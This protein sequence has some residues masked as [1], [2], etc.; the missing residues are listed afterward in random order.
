[1]MNNITAA[2]TFTVTVLYLFAMQPGSLHAASIS[3]EA[4]TPYVNADG[5]CSLVEAIDNAND[6]AQTHADC[7]PGSGTDI[8]TLNQDVTLDGSTTFN[9]FGATGLPA[10]TSAVTIEGNDKTIQR[11]TAAPGFRLLSVDGGATVTLQNLTLRGGFVDQGFDNGGGVYNGGTLTLIN[12]TIADN[13]VVSIF[14]SGGGIYNTGTLTIIDSTVQ[15]NSVNNATNPFDNGGGVYS[16]GALT[17]RNSTI[18]GNTAA[19]SGGGIYVN[20]D[21]TID[22]SV[23]S[24]NVAAVNGGGMVAIGGAS[25]GVHRIYNTTFSDNTAGERGGGL[26]TGSNDIEIFGSTF[27]ANT[28]TGSSLGVGGGIDASIGSITITNSTFDGNRALGAG[29]GGAFGAGITTT[30]TINGSVFRNN[31]AVN[32]GGALYTFGEVI[33]NDSLISGNTADRGG[34]LFKDASNV[35][36]FTVNRS[37]VIGNSAT[38]FGGGLQ[39]NGNIPTG[40]STIINSTFTGNSTPGFAGGGIMMDSGGIIDIRYS[41]VV[42]NEAT[43]VSNSVGGINA[44]G[45]EMTIGST[46]V[47]NNQNLDCSA[48]SASTSLDFNITTGVAD[49]AL[50][51][52]CSFIP[53]QP[54]DQTSTDPLL[55]PISTL[56]NL[57]SVYTLQAGSPAAD[58]V[59]VSC[60]PETAGVD[61]RGVP[62]EPGTCDVGS[63]SDFAAV[64]PQVY[65][66]DADIVIDDEG[67]FA[68]VQNVNIVVDNTAGNLPAPGS[69]PLTVYVTVLGTAAN[70]LDHTLGVTTPTVFAFNAGNWVTPGNTGTVS[71]PID[72]IDDLLI[73]GDETIELALSITGPGEARTGQSRATVTIVDDDAP[74]FTIGD[75]LAVNDG[76]DTLGTFTVVLDTPPT[77]N[78][79]LDVASDNTALAEVDTPTLMFDAANWNVPQTV[80][81]TRVV[82]ATADTGETVVVRVG[83]SANN[84][85]DAFDALPAQTVDVINGVVRIEDGNVINDGDDDNDDDGDD[86]APTPGNAR[87]DDLPMLVLDSIVELQTA[88]RASSAMDTLTVRFN[89]T[90][91]GGTDANGAHNPNNYILTAPGSDG[92]FDR[93]LTCRDWKQSAPTTD[94]VRLLNIA[95]GFTTGGDG[96]EV[97]LQFSPPLAAG[98]YRLLVCGTSSIVAAADERLVLNNGAFDSSVE[99]TVGDPLASVDM[100]PATGELPRWR[101]YMFVAIGMIALSGAHLLV[102]LRRNTAQPSR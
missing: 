4:P 21:A 60:P 86:D 6:D 83:V 57:Q 53:I 2:V 33:I 89:Q 11:A 17:L 38:T 92:A 42:D 52:W 80:T 13:Q 77:G 65:F 87:L 66:A 9:A 5:V 67:T 44:F 39:Q 32:R 63:V 26:A 25:V 46:I 35:P 10:I 31:S 85:A 72:V 91:R 43:S 24:G 93:T 94:D 7:P 28:V 69:V 50:T 20:S 96:T 62:R 81:V 34:G 79:V 15:N 37:T 22:N 16:T 58:A 78:V 36:G 51:R 23:I 88:E 47:A 12:T 75:V 1:M 68:G 64:L 59:P 56:G 98:D 45:G 100:L 14:P 101:N 90:V 73:E 27:R 8:I 18:S 40:R 74:G 102:R 95:V 71:I 30:A 76:S 61:Q 84:S 48:T 19:E 70:T 54:N 29:L 55:N 99:F 3:V 97:V 82:G 41:T 49:I